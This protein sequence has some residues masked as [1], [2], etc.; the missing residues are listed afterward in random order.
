MVQYG[1][2][3]ELGR[4]ENRWWQ[5]GPLQCSASAPRGA[6]PD[7]TQRPLRLAGPGIALL[8]KVQYQGRKAM[9]MSPPSQLMGLGNLCLP[10][11]WALGHSPGQG[12]LGSWGTCLWDFQT[13]QG[14]EPGLN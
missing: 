8:A 4:V 6:P 2:P 14:V 1:E 13:Y 11:L 5:P 9:W 3:W 10:L 7:S 12:C